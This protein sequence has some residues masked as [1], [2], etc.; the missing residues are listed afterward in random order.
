MYKLG[1]RYLKVVMYHCCIFWCFQ[2]PPDPHKCVCSTKGISLYLG[3]FFDEGLG[4]LLTACLI[5]QGMAEKNVIQ[6]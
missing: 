2:H 6:M 3:H 5:H 4:D 1:H